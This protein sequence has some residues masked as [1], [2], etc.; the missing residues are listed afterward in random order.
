MS[1]Q[2]EYF[3]V[4]HRVF[5]V[6]WTHRTYASRAEAQTGMV[7]CARFYSAVRIV[8]TTNPHPRP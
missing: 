1:E 7:H 4:E 8:T 5:D 3:R 2:T 6:W